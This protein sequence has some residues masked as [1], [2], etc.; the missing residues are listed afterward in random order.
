MALRHL[1][2]SPKKA[3]PGQMLLVVRK[4]QDFTDAYTQIQRKGLEVRAV[5]ALVFRT[6]R[7]CMLEQRH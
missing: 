4:C 3:L 1:G 7:Y 6:S 2:G 5:R